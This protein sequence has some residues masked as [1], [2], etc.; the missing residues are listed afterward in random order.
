MFYIAYKFDF[1][2]PKEYCIRKPPVGGFLNKH[3]Q[4]IQYLRDTKG[5]FTHISW[6]TRRQAVIFTG[7]III[8]SV[9][10]SAYLGISDTIFSAILKSFVM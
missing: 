7:L 8:F 6:P 4:I 3:M 2:S 9:I 5:E 10:T 1:S